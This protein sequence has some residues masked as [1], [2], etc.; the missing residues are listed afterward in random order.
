MYLKLHVTHCS[1][2]RPPSLSPL[3]RGK[4]NM[5]PNFLR[6]YRPECLLDGRLDGRD[7]GVRSSVRLVLENAGQPEVT[8]IEILGAGGLNVLRQHEQHLLRAGGLAPFWP[9]SRG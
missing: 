8:R 5:P 7:G 1:R 4:L 9:R 6:L 3:G 2:P